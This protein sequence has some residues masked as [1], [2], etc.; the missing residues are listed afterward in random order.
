MVGIYYEAYKCWIVGIICD[1]AELSEYV[2]QRKNT[3]IQK[4]YE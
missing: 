3:W 1:N 2:L 4:L